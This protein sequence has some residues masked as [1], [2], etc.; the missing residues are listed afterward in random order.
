[1]KFLFYSYGYAFL[2]SSEIGGDVK[3]IFDSIEDIIAQA[4]EVD[5]KYL[6]VQY[7]YS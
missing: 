5:E 7:I 1:V 2:V 3:K 6:Q 4:D